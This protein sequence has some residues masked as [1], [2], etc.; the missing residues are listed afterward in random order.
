MSNFNKVLI[1]GATGFIGS[2]LVK[3]LVREKRDVHIIT[4]ASSNL[5][6]LRDVRDFIHVHVYDESFDSLLKIVH[7]AQPSTVFHLASEFIAQHKSA[8]VDSLFQNNV[9]FPSC[10]AEAMAVCGVKRLINTGTSWQYFDSTT[11]RPVNLYAATKQAFEDVIAYYADV[12]EWR[13]ITLNLFDTYGPNDPRP[14]LMNLLLQTARNQQEL[15]LSPGNQLIDLVHI[16][17]VVTAYLK[18]E[19]SL[20]LMSIGHLQYGVSSQAPVQLKE[21]VSTCEDAWGVRLP[22]SWGARP[23]RDRE[24]MLPWNTYKKIPEWQPQVPLLNGL[25]QVF[26]ESVKK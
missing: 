13:V 14:K 9:V 3:A 7:D 21:L 10:L 25:K 22:V 16:N 17:D 6:P 18:A 20:N 23:Y 1:T 12:Y 5:D 11:Y 19:S 15:Q 26:S 8:Q 24:V 2:N 4:R